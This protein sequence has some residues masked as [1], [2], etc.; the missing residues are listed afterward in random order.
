MTRT[1]LTA[2]HTGLVPYDRSLPGEKERLAWLALAPILATGL[3]YLVPAPFQ[4]RLGVL[5]LPQALAYL[6][7]AIWTAQ[8]TDIVR[9]LGLS[10]SLLKEGLQWGIPTGLVLGSL[11]V[12][13]ILRLVPLLG[14]D[15][16][17]LRETPHARA[18]AALMLP[19]GILL[20]AMAVE[21]NFRGFLLGRLLA[22]CQRAWL[23]RFPRVGQVLAPTVAIAGASTVFAFDP[24]MATTFKHLHWIAI[25][26]GLVWGTIWLRLR[27][28]YAP[29]VAHAVEVMMM[30][31]IIKVAL[32]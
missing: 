22:L 8:N 4:H 7:F 2:R 17:F 29:I 26:D 5:F 27:N 12:A 24:F 14:G 3:F 20:I 31:S 11:N 1:D 30:Y 28:L 9:R 25:W 15:I 10:W 13:V 19:W 32:A 6:G 18:P 23:S 16:E 21:L